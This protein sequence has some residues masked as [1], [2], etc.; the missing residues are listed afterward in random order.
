MVT[1]S[2]Y[3][4]QME[5]QRAE[6]LRILSQ[7]SRDLEAQLRGP[8][9]VKIKIAPKYVEGV[10]VS[11]GDEQYRSNIRAFGAKNLAK[12]FGP[13]KGMSALEQQ[14]RLDLEQHFSNASGMR[15][16][17]NLCTQAIC[18]LVIQGAIN[19]TSASPASD[20]VGGYNALLAELKGATN[21]SLVQALSNL[22][23]LAANVVFGGKV[24]KLL[25]PMNLAH[26]ESV[27]A[28]ALPKVQ[29]LA[30]MKAYIA[31]GEAQTAVIQYLNKKAPSDAV[32]LPASIAIPTTAVVNVDAA[33]DRYVAKDVVATYKY[34]KEAVM[35]EVNMASGVRTGDVDASL[36]AASTALKQAASA[37]N[38]T[39]IDAKIQ[40]VFKS[41]LSSI[42]SSISKVKANSKDAEVQI[43]NATANLLDLLGAVRAGGTP[44]AVITGISGVASNATFKSNLVALLQAKPSKFAGS[45]SSYEQSVEFLDAQDNLRPSNVNVVEI[46]KPNLAA[47]RNNLSLALLSLEDAYTELVVLSPT[48]MPIAL[49][50]KQLKITTGFKDLVA[51]NL[52]SAMRVIA[53]RK[54]K[55]GASVSNAVFTK[56][57]Q[58]AVNQVLGVNTTVATLNTP[59]SWTISEMTYNQIAEGRVVSMSAIESGLLSFIDKELANSTVRISASVRRATRDA[60]ISSTELLISTL[61]GLR[62]QA[63]NIGMQIRSNPAGGFFAADTYGKQVGVGA[64]ALYSD[65]ASSALIN[66]FAKPASGSIG[67][68]ASDYGVSVATALWGAS[69]VTGMKVPVLNSE[70]EENKGLGYSM[71]AGSALHALL[72]TLYKNNVGNMRFSNSAFAKIGQALV[73]APAHILGDESMGYSALNPAN[74]KGHE[75]DIAAWVT[76]LVRVT[77]KSALCHIGSQLW[78]HG[79]TVA[80]ET[81]NNIAF[82]FTVGDAPEIA[83]GKLNADQQAALLNTVGALGA[84]CHCVCEGCDVKC[85]GASCRIAKPERG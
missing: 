85:E 38:I 3:V 8:R 69:F 19:M 21:G 47:V 84:L 45:L 10:T 82:T 66:R 46:R 65:H 83:E 16:Y 75:S 26:I 40:R 33:F 4:R 44:G 1:T 31:N 68:Y 48:G 55:L 32:L 62:I 54:A 53:S 18:H 30:A 64:L 58:E 80:F 61:N 7:L 71:I 77:P 79:L 12:A 76:N 81:A 67:A 70:G 57:L 60:V 22:D 78:H 23:S 11:Q 15:D 73:T 35:A 49:M 27:T 72:R 2:K 29:E 25:Y 74:P 28:K 51:N 43:L 37:L 63:E 6:D 39:G 20:L 5:E 42:S 34:Y 36:S 41:E 13:N 56:G 14:T 9:E 17:V 52:A 24:Y 50:P 59:G